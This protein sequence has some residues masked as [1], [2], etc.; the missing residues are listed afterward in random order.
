MR[1][2]I[3]TEIDG[4]WIIEEMVLESVFPTTQKESSYET[5]A[6]LLQILGIKIPVT[7]Q[8]FPERVELNPTAPK[9]SSDE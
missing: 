7:A 1:K 3:L 6:R 4:H 2:I 8:S 5:M 9:E